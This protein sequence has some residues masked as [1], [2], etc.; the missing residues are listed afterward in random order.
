MEERKDAWNDCVSWD[1]RPKSLCEGLN[2][3]ADWFDAVYQ[4]NGVV[5]EDLRKWADD[6]K[7]L[8]TDLAAAQE[9]I[10]ELEAKLESKNDHSR[11][12]ESLLEYV[13]GEGWETLTIHEAKKKKI[14]QA[15][16]SHRNNCPGA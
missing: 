3:L 5:Q 13:Y 2:I 6:Y 11:F 12:L 9:S 1:D 4:D 8:E 14:P 10:E 16:H 15:H 7:Q